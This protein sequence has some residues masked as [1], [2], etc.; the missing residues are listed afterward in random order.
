VSLDSFVYSR[1]DQKLLP[2]LIKISGF[3]SRIEPEEEME[4]FGKA[5]NRGNGRDEGHGSVMIS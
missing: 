5:P 1:T 3:L 4:L 2:F